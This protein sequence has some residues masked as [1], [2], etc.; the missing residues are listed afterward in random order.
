[1]FVKMRLKAKQSRQIISFVPN[2]IYLHCVH[3]RTSIVFTIYIVSCRWFKVNSASVFEDAFSHL[4]LVRVSSNTWQIKLG[5]IKYKYFAYSFLKYFTRFF[6][7]SQL[8]PLWIVYF[9]DLLVVLNFFNHFCLYN[10]QITGQKKQS[11]G[12]PQELADAVT[13]K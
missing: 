10:L 7:I 1:M 8:F 3:N 6:H 11:A 2:I 13:W 9:K 5:K 12:R 4:S